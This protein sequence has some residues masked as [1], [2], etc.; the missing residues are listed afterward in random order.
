MVCINWRVNRW[1]LNI[2]AGIECEKWFHSVPASLISSLQY[3]VRT[4]KIRTH[5]NPDRN[6]RYGHMNSAGNNGPGMNVSR[7]QVQYIDHSLPGACRHGDRTNRNRYMAVCPLRTAAVEY[8][9]GRDGRTG[10]RTSDD[11]C[12]VDYSKKW[13][14]FSK[15]AWQR[16][17]RVILLTSCP[18]DSEF[19]RETGLPEYWIS[20]LR[21]ELLKSRSGKHTAPW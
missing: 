14:R 19:S 18:R 17:K 15:N 2:K 5:R 3:S 1:I 7:I 20:E 9:A 4:N 11:D 16:N 8:T 13:K 6:A 12:P 21:E 10:R